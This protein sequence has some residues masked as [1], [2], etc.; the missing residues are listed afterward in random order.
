MLLT[1]GQVK[2]DMDS[3]EDNNANAAQAG[4][5]VKRSLPVVKAHDDELELHS[6]WLQQMDGG[7]GGPISIWHKLEQTQDS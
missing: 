5:S 1:G 3:S 4:K 2:L 6:A 7:K